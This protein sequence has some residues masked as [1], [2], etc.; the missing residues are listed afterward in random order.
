MLIAAVQTHRCEG[1]EK[2]G[3]VAVVIWLSRLIGKQK[4]EK[5]EIYQLIASPQFLFHFLH[6]LYSKS[7]IVFESKYI[8]KKAPGLFGHLSGWCYL[9]YLL[10]WHINIPCTVIAKHRYTC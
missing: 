2:G 9:E 3:V 7:H 4:K 5:R 10:M 6:V 1:Q 8:K